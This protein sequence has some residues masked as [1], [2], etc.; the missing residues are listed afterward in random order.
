MSL[1]SIRGSPT[2]HLSLLP[3][4]LMAT[5]TQPLPGYSFWINPGWLHTSWREGQGALLEPAACI[6][7]DVKQLG[8][9]GSLSVSSLLS[10]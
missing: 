5:G 10:F 4:P 9:K 8:D 6:E 7:S 3:L 2:H 1:D